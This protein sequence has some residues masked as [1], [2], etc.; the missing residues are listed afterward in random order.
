[1]RIVFP[2]KENMSYISHAASLQEADYLTVLRVRG[3]NI[4][5]VETIKNHSYTSNDELVKEFKANQFGVVVTPD[6]NSLPVHKLK[7]AGIS[8]YED[9]PSQLVLEAF[10]EFVQDKLIRIY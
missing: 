3:Q 6:A 4:T 8:V 2:T 7:S 10:S 1:M 9:E 5:G